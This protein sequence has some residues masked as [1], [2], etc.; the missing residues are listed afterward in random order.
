M[1]KSEFRKLIQEEIRKVLNEASINISPN[2]IKNLKDAVNYASE[3]P[4]DSYIMK[5]IESIVSDIYKAA[6]RKD[7]KELASFTMEDDFWED[8]SKYSPEI[9]NALKAHI[10]DDD[11]MR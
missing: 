6:G 5:D 10:T 9:L 2:L 8:R 11:D 3:N 1:K 7:Y 4:D